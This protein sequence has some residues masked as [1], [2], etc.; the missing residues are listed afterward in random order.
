MTLRNQIREIHK[1]HF[2][3]EFHAYRG[4]IIPAM[5]NDLA[6]KFFDELQQGF[7]AADYWSIAN[8]QDI[9]AV[10]HARKL[11]QDIGIRIDTPAVE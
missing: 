1:K 9:R 6:L 2:S 5:L 4:E 11:M 10:K 3:A 7:P 8:S